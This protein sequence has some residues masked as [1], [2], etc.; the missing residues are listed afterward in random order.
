MARSARELD[1]VVD[2]ARLLSSAE[3]TTYDT[4]V[5]DAAA[6]RKILQEDLEGSMPPC[7]YKKKIPLRP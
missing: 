5:A 1:E 4:A 7:I 2:E 6:R 3:N